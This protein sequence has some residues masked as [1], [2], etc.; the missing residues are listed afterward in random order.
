MSYAVNLYDQNRQAAAFVDKTLKGA[1]PGDLPWSSQQSS[2][3][4]STSGLPRRWGWP[5]RR[6]CWC[7]QI[8]SLSENPT[9]NIAVEGIAGSRALAAFGLM[10][11][12]T[13]G[14]R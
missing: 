10:T 14:E 9:S 11:A 6:R 13:R 3:W 2:N 1:K 7:E 4:S 5:F 12:A 8:R